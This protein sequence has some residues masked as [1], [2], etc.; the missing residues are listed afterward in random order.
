MVY[1][2]LVSQ[3]TP[4]SESIGVWPKTSELASCKSSKHNAEKMSSSK[5]KF[6]NGEQ[7][8]DVEVEIV[9]HSTSVSQYIK[10]KTAALEMA[11]VSHNKLAT[12]IMK[13]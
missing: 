6:T 9:K 3:A 11:M 2:T 4:P 5:L 7:E 12:C 1:A 10:T 8:A 13:S